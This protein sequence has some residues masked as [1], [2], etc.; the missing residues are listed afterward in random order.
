MLSY[1]LVIENSFILSETDLGKIS[2]ILFPF[3]FRKFDVRIIGVATKDPISKGQILK[4]SISKGQILK[5]SISKGQI[6]KDPKSKGP[7]FK[8]FNFQKVKFS[9]DPIF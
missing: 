1:G 9:K 8:R 6:L 2:W 5:G 3:L 7:I 4:D